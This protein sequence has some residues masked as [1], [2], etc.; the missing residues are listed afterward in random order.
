MTLEVRGPGDEELCF[1][2]CCS[3]RPMMFATLGPG[4]SIGNG[5]NC[6][7][8]C[9]LEG[10]DGKS[11]IKLELTLLRK[12]ERSI[13]GIPGRVLSQ[14]VALKARS[15]TEDSAVP[16]GMVRVGW[17]CCLAGEGGL[18]QVVRL[19]N[20][21]IRDCYRPRGQPQSLTVP[22]S[23]LFQ[24]HQ[25]PPASTHIDAQGTE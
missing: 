1:F 7:F 12:T 8:F 24:F 2:V 20:S 9:L 15:L 17:L 14:T 6:A 4:F 13:R 19:P 23:S 5:L 25:P 10:M 21:I 3:N 22:A 16:W 11:E 18:C